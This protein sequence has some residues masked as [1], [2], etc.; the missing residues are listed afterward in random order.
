MTYDLT[1]APAAPPLRGKGTLITGVV[2]L[3]LGLVAVIAGIA[4]LAGTATSLLSQ[5]GTPQTAPT[6]FTRQLDGGTT[7]AVYEAT[8]GGSGTTEDPFLGDVQATDITV[9]GPNGDVPVTSTGDQVNTVGDGKQLFAEVATFN[10]PTTGSYTIDISTTGSLV[11]VAPSLSSVGKAAIWLALIG[12]GGLLAVIGIIL[13]IVGAVQRSSSRKKQQAALAG[14][15]GYAA[16][17]GQPY[18]APG[19]AAPGYP[20]PGQ[21]APAEGYPTQAYPPAA[22]ADPYAA[23]AQP[24]APAES[25]PYAPP[26]AEPAA[27]AAP[28]AAAAPAPA[29]QPAALPPAGW[30]P[31]ADRPGGQRYWDGAAWTEHRA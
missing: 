22:A 15:A 13:L 1:G 25:Q 31:D 9:K 2:L 24:V 19:Y 11:A 14:A 6:S 10:P 28:A 4:L 5:I 18:G 8:D 17:P 12:L 30:Y 23:P 16:A 29:P 27:Y 21:P 26:T 20:A 7:Y 3:I